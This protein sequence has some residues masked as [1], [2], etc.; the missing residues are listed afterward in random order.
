MSTPPNPYQGQQQG[1]QQA[2]GYP[3]QPPQQP[4]PGFQQPQPNQG[5]QVQ[6]P[7]QPA[8]GGRTKR[9][10]KVLG[11]RLIVSVVALIV[12][13]VGGFIWDHATG[14]ADTAKVGDCVQNTGSDSNPN[15]HVLSCSDPNA[16]FKVLQV[17]N[18]SSDDSQCQNVQGVVAAYTESGSNDMVLCLGNNG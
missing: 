3:Q 14:A 4:N 1:Q 15:V 16:K 6:P 5:F 10:G 2:P 13:G 17:I 9:V 7:Q 18:N 11:I 12:I 8:P